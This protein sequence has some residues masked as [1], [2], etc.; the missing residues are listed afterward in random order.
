MRGRIYA[1]SLLS[2]TFMTL[3]PPI[4]ANAGSSTLKITGRV[5][6]AAI[7]SS[8]YLAY[9]DFLGYAHLLS[10]DGRELWRVKVTNATKYAYVD[11]SE[12]SKVAVLSEERISVLSPEGK[13][14][15][16]RE[17]PHKVHC[18]MTYPI[19]ISPDGRIV[20]VAWEGDR[21][22]AGFSG[23][24]GKILWQKI[25]KSVDGAYH[26]SKGK[27]LAVLEDYVLT[28]FNT[29]T[30]ERDPHFKEVFT[31]E[32][33]VD[34]E[35]YYAIIEMNTVTLYSP[36]GDEIWS[37]SFHG[38][39]FGGTFLPD[40][41]R[42]AITIPM[43]NGTQVL[44]L[45]ETGNTVEEFRKPFFVRGIKTSPDG[46][47]MILWGDSRAMYILDK[48]VRMLGDEGMLMDPG[49]QVDDLPHDE[50]ITVAVGSVGRISV[51]DTSGRKWSVLLPYGLFDFPGSIR[52]SYLGEV[53]TASLING[54]V[55]VLNS[56]DGSVVW[57]VDREVAFPERAFSSDDARYL[58]AVFDDDT[59]FVY[60]NSNGSA[61]ALFAKSCD[62]PL[63]LPSPDWRTII[64]TSGKEVFLT[65]LRGEI[66]WRLDLDSYP[67]IL[68][69]L[70]DRY[71]L[72]TGERTAYLLSTGGTIV[73]SLRI[74]GNLSNFI[75]IGENDALL[76]IYRSGGTAFELMRMNLSTGE[77]TWSK[78]FDLNQY[79]V[80]WRGLCA[81]REGILLG[82]ITGRVYMLADDGSLKQVR[83][84]EGGVDGLFCGPKGP[85][86][87]LLT[88]GE[89]EVRGTGVKAEER[90]VSGAVPPGSGTAVRSTRVSA[91]VSGERISA[92]F[93]IVGI[94]LLVFL[95]GTWLRLRSASKWGEFL[96]GVSEAGGRAG[97]SRRGVSRRGTPP[98]SPSRPREQRQAWPRAP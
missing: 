77:I 14:I 41:R 9:T 23:S 62:E 58:L 17:N 85:A 19:K 4:P 54:T 53:V 3:I 2:L 61:E 75:P 66:K 65:S 79:P 96:R 30:G 60:E 49:T 82:D 13:V 10:P 68:V 92:A 36:S 81:G 52:F 25:L 70:R 32:P 88:V 80:W 12:D 89:I 24:D 18:W 16:S 64:F 57:R 37:Q 21:Y 55:L 71:L 29:T 86:L 5:I 67:N 26:S 97:D 15:W 72:S 83:E 22:I 84:L 94:V 87:V 98:P 46:S 35:G 28:V 48:T 69:T 27:Y 47:H 34:D 31:M 56:T 59:I 74:D 8:R 43:G 39:I 95:L 44:I 20:V 42:M 11:I 73:R 78:N 76:H 51:Y 7:S 50:G 90:G 6:S 1:Y 93:G 45:N 33:L 38:I 40:H 91:S 63:A